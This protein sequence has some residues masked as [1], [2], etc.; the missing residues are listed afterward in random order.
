MSQIAS[1]LRF[2]IRITNRNR[3]QIARFGALRYVLRKGSQ[4][5]T[6]AL[7]KVLRSGA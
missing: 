2:A 1:D 6:R 7:Q 4:I 5:L 3:N